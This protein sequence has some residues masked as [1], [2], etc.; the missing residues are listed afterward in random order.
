MEITA[1]NPIMLEAYIKN[2]R[3]KGKTG[4]SS[5]QAS[6]EILRE[7]K[8]V[9]SPEAREIQEAKK[10]LNSL[11]DIRAEKVAHLKK[12]IENGT[13]QIK[14]EKIAIKMLK[15]SLNIEY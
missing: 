6:E 13:Y 8:V 4:P 12:Q 1:K 9:L 7:D 5:K 14:G 2:L 15:E 3:D 10:L 11:P